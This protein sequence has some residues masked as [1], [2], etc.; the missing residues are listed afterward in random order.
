MGVS[1]SSYW[2]NVD[3]T[4]EGAINRMRRLVNGMTDEEI[5]QEFEKL[6]YE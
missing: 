6:G 3:N 2:A 1:F 4:L 5:Q